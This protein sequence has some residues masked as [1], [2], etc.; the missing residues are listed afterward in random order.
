MASRIA[1]SASWHARLLAVLLAVYCLWP[2]RDSLL[3]TGMPLNTLGVAA[4]V[5][6]ALA[7]ICLPPRPRTWMVPAAGALLLLKVAIVPFVLPTGWAARYFT[8]DR[9]AGAHERSIDFRGEPW[10]R[11]ERAL[12]FEGDTFPLHF[13]NRLKFNFTPDRRSPAFSAVYEGYVSM[14]RPGTLHTTVASTGGFDVIVDGQQVLSRPASEQ[15][16]VR[17]TAAVPLQAGM[18]RVEVR[19][20]SPSKTARKLSVNLQWSDDGNAGVRRALP[21]PRP[22]SATPAQESRSRWL[23]RL[24]ALADAALLGLVALFAGGAFHA[25]WRRV[26]PESPAR[27]PDTV[28]MATLVALG[29]LMVALYAS[30][31]RIPAPFV[32]IATGW[33]AMAFEEYARE[34]VL[35]DWLLNGRETGLHGIALF[36]TIGYHLTMSAAHVLF[37]ESMWNVLF[38][39]DWLLWCSVVLGAGTAV[40]I[41]GWPAGVVAFV[42]G[43]YFRTY[44]FFPQHFLLRENLVVFMNAALV[45]VCTA[46]GPWTA[47]RAACIGVVAGF[48]YLTDPINLP[49][50]PVLMWLVYR[51]S[52]P[53]RRRQP[54]MAFAIACL[55]LVLLIPVRNVLVTGK[56]VLIPTEGAPTLHYGNRPP[57]DVAPNPRPEE[58]HSGHYRAVWTYAMKEPSHLATQ[59]ASRALFTFGFFEGIHTL[60]IYIAFSL[61]VILTWVCAAVGTGPAVRKHIGSGLIVL[62]AL[63]RVGSMV[64]FLATPRYVAALLMLLVPLAATGLV[65]AWRFSPVLAAIAV[66]AI[67]AEHVVRTSPELGQLYAWPGGRLI[68]SASYHTLRRGLLPKFPPAENLR[69]TFPADTARWTTGP[70]SAVID[71]ETPTFQFLGNDEGIISSPAIGVPA[72]LVETIEIEAGF[73]GLT[74]IARLVWYPGPV[75]SFFPVDQSGVV[76]TYRI[77][78]W[79]SKD[80]VN[81]ID[82][83]EIWYD[84]DTIQPKRIELMPYED[85]RQVGQRRAGP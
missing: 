28:T 4:C 44:H 82:R 31:Q 76:R 83:I 62:L 9:F 55:A 3:V 24:L 12:Q 8:N 5:A 20:I 48:N 43:A 13:F 6:L 23:V 73:T 80:W 59:V 81:T 26:S 25:W 57:A 21:L 74:N 66:F 17:R 69:W 2:A 68:G 10:T 61:A 79:Q 45:F 67:G 60:Y 64:V 54:V 34:F 7:L 63:G 35:G 33:D 36:Y 58:G 71:D 77:P 16:H 78:V 37:G 11:L 41:G 39:Q 27:T 65:S 15:G 52:A 51:M 70:S 85:V 47:R 30:W 75:T 38:L 14:E 18:R 40:R 32:F 46:R 53:E 49:V 42:I 22:I 50:L 19:Y 29:G 84:G 56:L 1:I 72:P